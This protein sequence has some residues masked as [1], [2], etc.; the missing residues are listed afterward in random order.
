[1]SDADREKWN[2]RYREGSYRARTHPSELIEQ[3][4]PQLPRGR[5]LDVAAGAGR[6]SLF[7]AASGF[8]VDA[9]DI[10]GE[11][12]ARLKGDAEK[13]GVEIDTI[14]LDLESDSLPKRQ[15]A[16]IVMVRYTNGN[17]IPRLLTLLDDGGHFLCEEHL[18]TDADVIGPT[19]PAFRV[20]PNELR[21]LTVASGLEI[22]HYSE[23]LVEDPDGRTAA[24]ARLVARKP[25]TV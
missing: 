15:Y 7:L 19:D 23:G 13:R 3:W 14:E 20:R 22:L 4:L 17:L 10:S 11:A 24:L 18:E 8:D 12:L 25:Q 2:T 21:E 9:L 5:A 6:N 1:M 16:L